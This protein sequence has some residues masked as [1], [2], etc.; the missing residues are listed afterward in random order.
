MTDVYLPHE[1]ILDYSQLGDICFY[2]AEALSADERLIIAYGYEG[3][4]HKHLQIWLHPKCAHALARELLEWHA[5]SNEHG[6]NLT[7][8]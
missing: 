2:C 5:E 6:R 8:E 7:A 3:L 4:P 1:E